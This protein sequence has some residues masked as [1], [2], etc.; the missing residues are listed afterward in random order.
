MKLTISA[1]ALRSALD[2]AAKAVGRD[3]GLPILG[4]VLLEAAADGRLVATG[5]D[6]RA[7]AQKAVPADVAQPGAAC[8]PPK[9]INDALDAA[10]HGADLTIA[11]GANHRAVLTCGRTVVKVAGQDAEGFPA[12]PSFSSPSASFELGAEAF[13][14]AVGSVAFAAAT[15]DGR[16]S[17]V[18]VLIEGRD[19]ELALTAADGKRIAYR[20]IAVDGVPDL[21]IVV[22]A[23]RLRQASSAIAKAIGAVRLSVDGMRSH[24]AIES[25]I[26]E[27]S[28][29]LIEGT[30][31]DLSRARRMVPTTLIGVDRAELLRAA[32]LV[33]NVMTAIEGDGKSTR[34]TKAIL[35]IGADGLEIRAGEAG[36]DHEATTTIDADLER[37]EPLTVALNSGSLKDA[38]D[39]LASQRVTLELEGPNRPILVRPSDRTDRKQCHV[40]IQMVVANVSLHAAGAA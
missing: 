34:A 12:A 37:G 13:R 22:P 27:W 16:P 3:R 6:L 26:G 18:G 36:A 29:K 19:G 5:T 1:H 24:L 40:I 21:S 15:D 28:I 23:D 39:A 20:A 7:R 9:A 25:A 14:D 33:I 8:L 30:Y 10:P 4:N 2:V 31:P 38:L 17:I 32:K 35:S 11:V